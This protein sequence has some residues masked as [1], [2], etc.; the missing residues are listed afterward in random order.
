MI[1]VFDKKENCC[2]CTSC[3]QICP[4]NAIKMIPDEEGFVYPRIDQ[5]LCID[6]GKCKGVC[7][8]QKG[9]DTTKNFKM[10]YAYG[11][12]HINEDI[13]MQ[14]RSGGMFTAVSDYILKKNGIVY[15]AG[16]NENLEVCHKRATNKIE[17]DELRG[18]KYVQ[19]DLKDTFNKVKMDLGTGKYVLFT[20]TPC[21]TAALDRYLDN[22]K[23]NKDLLLQSDIVCHGTPTPKVFKDYINYLE[24][25]YNNKIYEFQFRDKR[26]N[27]WDAHV[28]SFIINNNRY[29]SK[30][31]TK[32][33]Y[34]NSILRPSCYNCKY[35]NLVRPADITFADF[36]GVN[37]IIDE[38]NDNKGVSLVFANTEKGK[39]L[40][41]DVVNSL[42]Y[43]EC[44]NSSFIHPNLKKPTQKP[45]NREQF[46][47]DYNSLGLEYIIKKYANQN[48]FT[49]VKMK[50]KSIYKKWC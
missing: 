9:Y 35:T 23:T 18:S 45:L 39:K 17:R 22:S 46:W 40:F 44:T 48:F 28:E 19:S 30:T 10:P 4:T 16:F 41:D 49:R 33:F 31:Y 20:G 6:C 38:F 24:D 11:V 14:S 29:L 36:W 3:E 8:F 37:D 34:A 13:R 42:I 25:K 2:G 1:S 15:G 5:E 32:L 50:L 43:Q 12:K 47:K 21:Q 27:G 26:L 7:T